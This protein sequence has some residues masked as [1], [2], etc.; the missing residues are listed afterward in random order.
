MK[1]TNSFGGWAKG[2]L[3]VFYSEQAA[4]EAVACWEATAAGL[5]G[6]EIRVMRLGDPLGGE[7]F[8][9]AT[10]CTELFGED[11]LLFDDSCG[12]DVLDTVSPLRIPFIE[13]IGRFEKEVREASAEGDEQRL[14]DLRERLRRREF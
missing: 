1:E 14:R 8:V 7:T 11:T 3:G 10:N 13:R 6:A 5:P 2:V 12:R 9:V 4:S